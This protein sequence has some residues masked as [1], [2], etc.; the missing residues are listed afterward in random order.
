MKKHLQV[1]GAVVVREGKVLAARRGESRYPYVAH[2]YEFVG[3]KVEAGETEEE[4]LLRELREELRVQARV[5]A[6]F[7]CVTHEYPDFI[8]TLHTYRCEFLS[9]FCNTEH[10]ALEWMPLA[11][12]DPAAW[13][14]ADAPVVQKLRDAPAAEKL[15]DTGC[16]GGE[17]R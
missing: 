15:R 1:V 13:A 5:L 8:V 16:H 4:A 3:G 2:K 6:P 9:D 17:T 11:A 14:P 10:E 7:A 12:L